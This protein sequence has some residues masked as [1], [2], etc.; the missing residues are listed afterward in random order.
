M[1]SQNRSVALA[2]RQVSPNLAQEVVNWFGYAVS[3]CDPNELKAQARKLI[4]KVLRDEY[5]SFEDWYGK[6]SYLAL[7]FLKYVNRG[8]P[9]IEFRVDLYVA[10]SVHVR[11]D[12]YNEQQAEFAKPL[13]NEIQKFKVPVTFLHAVAEGDLRRLS[14]FEV[15]ERDRDYITLDIP[16]FGETRL[17]DGL[18]PCWRSFFR[19]KRIGQ[20]LSQAGLLPQDAGGIIDACLERS[21]S[22]PQLASGGYE[23][24]VNGLLDLG[25]NKPDAK[26]R[27]KYLMEKYP[28]ATLEERIRYALSS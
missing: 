14:Q 24:L 4:A 22:V 1:I 9:F 2:K 5:G 26:E 21:A 28:N 12:D 7:P 18:I 20:A 11:F 13:K 25:W 16:G 19:G 8:F 23:D 15:V 10:A 3:L 6:W 27:A 17:R